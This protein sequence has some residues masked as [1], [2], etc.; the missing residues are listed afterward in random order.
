[1]KGKWGMVFDK[2]GLRK[3]YRDDYVAR[4]LLDGLIERKTGASS[5]TVNQVLEIIGR[6]AATAG[7]SEAARRARVTHILRELERLECGSYVIGRRGHE[8]RFMWRYIAMS[9]GQAAAGKGELIEQA[10]A[11]A[12]AAVPLEAKEVAA[13]G[14]LQVTFPLRL[15]LSITL[16]LPTDLTTAE[17][18]RLSDF[19]KTLP[20]SQV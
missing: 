17:A 7:G 6:L 3:L 2:Q 11:T 1:M 15:S 18:A 5:T 12:A 9:V 19:I 8:S 16:N 13:N 14:M 20:F 4:G 10:N